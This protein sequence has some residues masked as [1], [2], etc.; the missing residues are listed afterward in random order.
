[1]NYQI[2]RNTTIDVPCPRCR[3]KT[4]KSLREMESNRYIHIKCPKCK[5]DIR[6]K[7]DLSGVKKAEDAINRGVQDLKRR[8]RHLR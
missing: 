5:A 1:M 8:L 2:D 7:P 4:K 3:Y 6:L